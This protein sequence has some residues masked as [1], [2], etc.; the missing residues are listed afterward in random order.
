MAETSFHGNIWNQQMPV[1]KRHLLMF[2][3]Q[4]EEIFAYLLENDFITSF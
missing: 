1:L 2:G 3:H 4:G